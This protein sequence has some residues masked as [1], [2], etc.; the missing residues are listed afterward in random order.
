MTIFSRTNNPTVRTTKTAPE[1]GEINYIPLSGVR[2]IRI[3]V[4]P[5]QGVVV[6][7][8]KGVSKKKVDAF[9]D[10]KQAWI[11]Q[12]LER[13]RVTESKS[14]RHFSTL[15][16]PSPATI[17]KALNSRLAELAVTHGFKHGRVSI[18]NQKSRWGSC[19]AQNNI[20]LNQKLYFLPDHLRDYVLIHELAHTKEKNHS[21]AFWGILFE[22]IGK[23]HTISRRRELKSFDYL[24]YPPPSST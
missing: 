22:I 9:I 8:P 12:T 3:F 24:F 6:K 4:R 15:I 14:I 1:F 2:S 21:Q 7:Y 11:R 10:S 5:F 17:R 16:P 23:T 13:T 19:S 18:R 20:S